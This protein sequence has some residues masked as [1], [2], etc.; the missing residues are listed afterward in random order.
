V[1]LLLPPRRGHVKAIDVHRRTA[2]IILDARGG[3]I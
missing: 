1:V 2:P 3:A